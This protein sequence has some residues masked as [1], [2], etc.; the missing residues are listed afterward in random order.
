MHDLWDNLTIPK[1][2]RTYPNLRVRLQRRVAAFFA[3]IQTKR[4]AKALEALQIAFYDE[5]KRLSEQEQNTFERRALAVYATG[6]LEISTRYTLSP[7]IINYS[8]SRS[9][10]IS[11]GTLYRWKR[12]MF[13]SDRLKTH[14]YALAG[15][16]KAVFDQCLSDFIYPSLDLFDEQRDCE[17]QIQKHAV[18]M[19][20]D[21]FDRLSA[22]EKIAFILH[23]DPSAYANSSLNAISSLKAGA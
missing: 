11:K 14:W 3:N 19:L 16:N 9:F 1:S 21:Q 2:F 17:Q 10:G 8:T 20:E 22:D 15:K 18:K 12:D 13:S 4:E 6:C 7:S 5:I 23:L